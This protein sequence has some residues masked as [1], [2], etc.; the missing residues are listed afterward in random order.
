MVFFVLSFWKI[1]IFLFVRFVNFKFMF[2]SLLNIYQFLC[3]VSL[4]NI[5]YKLL[6][7]NLK[8]A[9]LILQNIF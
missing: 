4:T 6:N 3:Y 2:I 8:L 5:I 7:I 1:V 9:K